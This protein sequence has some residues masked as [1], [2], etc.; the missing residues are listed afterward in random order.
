M[1]LKKKDISLLIELFQDSS[2][3]NRQI[4][5]KIGVS[6]ETVGNRIDYFKDNGI[7]KAF[8]LQIDYSLFNFKNFDIFIRLKD[9]DFKKVNDVMQYLAIHPNSIWIGRAF[10]KYDI[11]V[12]MYLKEV[13]DINV[14]IKEFH[15]KFGAN[16]DKIDS[17][18]VTSRFKAS[19]NLFLENLFDQ[20]IELNPIN[21]KLEKK[22]KVKNIQI[23]SID[24][25][26]LFELGQG[27]KRNLTEIAIQ[28]EM[29]AEAVK[30]RIKQL[31]NKG[32]ITGNSLNI[33]GNKLGKI[34]CLTLLNINPE[35]ISEFKTSLSSQKFLS[36][37]GESIGIWNM[38]VQFF[39][40]SIEGLY[41]E[42]NTI[43]SDFHKEI[44]DFEI[45]IFFEE[46]K[47]PKVPKCIL[48]E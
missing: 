5:R 2:Q 14:I 37:Y 6:K 20:K 32:I 30:Y 11:K 8:S 7:I 21:S 47:Y 13:L 12:T 1:N 27:N 23:D 36:N 18:Y 15:D 29:S 26:I 43:R 40:N 28:L 33:N 31:T 39:A 3:S 10:G 45:M 46:I 48:D 22:S 34:W 42:L 24:R 19:A 41:E 16:I 4:A 38:Y 17:I 9:S 25:K 35:K 44:R